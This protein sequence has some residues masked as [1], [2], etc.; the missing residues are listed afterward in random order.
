VS[1]GR[2]H[3]FDILDDVWR[4]G[5]RAVLVPGNDLSGTIDYRL[6]ESTRFSTGDQATCPAHAY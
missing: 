6:K 2:E 1:A 5:L 3:P 4:Q